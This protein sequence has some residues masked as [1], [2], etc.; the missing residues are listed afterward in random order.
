MEHK[1]RTSDLFNPSLSGL[2]YRERRTVMAEIDKILSLSK[3]AQQH[4]SDEDY[5]DN[6]DAAR[7]ADDVK[8]SKDNLLDVIHQWASRPSPSALATPVMPVVGYEARVLLK[9]AHD[10]VVKGIN[11]EELSNTDEYSKELIQLTRTLWEELQEETPADFGDWV[12]ATERQSQFGPEPGNI[13]RN[14]PTPQEAAQQEETANQRRIKEEEEQQIEEL[15]IPQNLAE[16]GI[17]H[18]FAA[19]DARAMQGVVVSDLPWWGPG[20]MAYVKDILQYVT[21]YPQSRDS[22]C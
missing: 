12:P 8:R 13:I 9:K 14:V 6:G 2:E 16:L 15:D 19:D 5:E 4:E 22:N 10:L 21:R 7:I 3:Q 17:E 1:Y 18:D 20:P 11:D